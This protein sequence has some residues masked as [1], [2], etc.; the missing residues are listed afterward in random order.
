[1]NNSSHMHSFA[2]S[3]TSF[4]I[5]PFIYREKLNKVLLLF[6][7]LTNLVVLLNV[8]VHPP[9]IGYDGYSHLKYVRKL[10]VRLPVK[11]DTS[12]Y[13]SPPLP[14]FFPSRVYDLCAR[15]DINEQWDDSS[16]QPCLFLAGKAGQFQNVL[17][18]VLLTFFLLKICELIYPGNLPVK[19]TTLGLLGML[20]VYYK[21]FAFVRGEPFVA[22]LGMFASYLV[23]EM[24]LDT[25]ACKPS[26]AIVLGI[27]LGLLMLARQ[28]SMLFF[29]A[30][31]LMAL[32]LLLKHGKE[33]FPVVKGF[34][35]SVVIAFLLGA[36]FYILQFLRYGTPTAFNRAPAATW[37]FLNQP[38][39]FYVGTGWQHL[40]TAPIRPFFPNQFIPIFYSEIWGDYWGYFVVTPDNLDYIGRY[41][42]RVNLVSL[43][44]SAILL[45]GLAMGVIY[46]KQFLQCEKGCGEDHR[47]RLFSYLLLVIVSAFAGYLWFLVRYPYLEK[48]DTIKAT[49]MLHVLV[50]LPLFGSDILE[51]VRVRAKYLY[52]ILL[53]ILALIFVHN[54]GVI[55]THYASEREFLL[56]ISPRAADMASTL[57]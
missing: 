28:W 13:F 16:L 49:Y 2:R 44:P 45:V 38:L 32:L 42:G 48:G 8:V 19:L 54:H 4:F 26:H 40:F 43:V 37:S 33:A 39:H 34:G 9:D 22:S 15:T 17:L 31:V 27:S 14:Y 56:R 20:P 29:P 12:E 36:W 11:G 47:A 5:G 50:L 51:K 46:L 41:L 35:L 7:L 6:F 25:R 23:L 57:D 10:A 3:L 1:M 55:I 30:I 52:V 18:S 24:I 21:T 53:A